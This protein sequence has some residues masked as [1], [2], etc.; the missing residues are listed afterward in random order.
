MGF[1]PSL[2]FSSASSSFYSYC[3]N[4]VKIASIIFIVTN[5]VNAIGDST[6]IYEA[7]CECGECY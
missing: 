5:V 4:H 6:K 1:L 7:M 3:K 2:V